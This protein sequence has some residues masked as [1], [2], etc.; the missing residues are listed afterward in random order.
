MAVLIWF[1]E[2]PCDAEI[3]IGFDTREARHQ[4]LA[5]VEGAGEYPFLDWLNNRSGRALPDTPD[6]TLDLHDSTAQLAAVLEILRE[7]HKI[8]AEIPNSEAILSLKNESTSQAPEV[9]AF[10]DWTEKY[11]KDKL[12]ADM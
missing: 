5:L 7:L 11:A 1:Q 8:T 12:Q 4:F 6:I 9:Q 2:L 10:F 3:G